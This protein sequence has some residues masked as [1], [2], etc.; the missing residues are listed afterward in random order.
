M[1]L[2]AN[3]QKT[4][5]ALVTVGQIGGHARQHEVGLLIGRSHLALRHK[6]LLLCQFVPA[7]PLLFAD[8]AWQS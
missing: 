8:V 3:E 6:A 5:E 4:D 1:Q 7:C 2:I